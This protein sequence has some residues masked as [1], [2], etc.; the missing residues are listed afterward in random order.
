LI[1]LKLEH[2]SHLFVIHQGAVAGEFL[3]VKLSDQRLASS[4]AYTPS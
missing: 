4:R 2:L 1:A 3:Q